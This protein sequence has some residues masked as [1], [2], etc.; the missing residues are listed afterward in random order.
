MRVALTD[1]C[2]ST[3]SKTSAGKA[4][5][6]DADASLPSSLKDVKPWSFCCV[7]SDMYVIGESPEVKNESKERE[8]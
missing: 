8:W 3:I 7:V 5:A 6:L 1:Y 2:T 4:S